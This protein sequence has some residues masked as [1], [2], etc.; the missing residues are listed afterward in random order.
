[1]VMFH[2]Q[3]VYS[4]VNTWRNSEL[5]CHPVSQLEPLK[6]KRLKHNIFAMVKHDIWL[7][8]IHP[9]ESLMCI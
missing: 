6:K 7:M 3:R 2:N 8:V 1:M 5:A 4:I 9:L